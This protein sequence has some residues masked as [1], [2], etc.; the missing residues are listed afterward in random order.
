MT[1]CSVDGKTYEM[2]MEDSP[3]FTV[4][5]KRVLLPFKG[6]DLM[7]YPVLPG[8]RSLTGEKIQRYL[9]SELRDRIKS[10]GV[11]VKVVDR[12]GRKE[13]I[14]VP[15]QFTGRLLHNLNP[16]ETEYGDIY[17]E[18]YLSDPGGS[19]QIGLYRRGTRA[20]NY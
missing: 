14:V 18:L 12:T 16:A 10:A 7:I 13:F 4:T 3:N 1:S 19:N 15:R 2:T 5:Q 17:L 6:T 11:T 8:L 9:A 20:I